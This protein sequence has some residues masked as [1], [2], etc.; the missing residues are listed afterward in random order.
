M[1]HGE[2]PAPQ[3]SD[4]STRAAAHVRDLIQ[5]DADL[6]P[7]W[8]DAMLALLADG[9]PADLGA[10]DALLTHQARG[11]DAEDQATPR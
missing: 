2:P 8:R 11:T 7:E 5:A 1:N 3:A 4:L 9:A 6:A 10:F